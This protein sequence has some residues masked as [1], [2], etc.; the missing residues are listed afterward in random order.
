MHIFN[1]SAYESFLTVSFSGRIRF[2][3][4]M[5]SRVSRLHTL[6]QPNP[7]LQRIYNSS[8]NFPSC[9]VRLPT[10]TRNPPN[11]ADSSLLAQPGHVQG[12]QHE[13]GRA[14]H[15]EAEVDAG[16]LPRGQ[17]EVGRSSKSQLFRPSR[18]NSG[19]STFVNSLTK[20]TTSSSNVS[21]TT[22][23]TAE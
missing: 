21:V 13:Q 10:S 1:R 22:T 23:S 12:A 16:E 9:Q 5:F 6:L 18:S 20:A 19:F 2:L 14:G 8:L 11:N 15:E 3:W 4:W 17:G 7:C